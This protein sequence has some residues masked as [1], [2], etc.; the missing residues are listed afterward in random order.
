MEEPCQQMPSSTCTRHFLS[1]WNRKLVFIPFR[2]VH[3]GAYSKF[4]H[5]PERL[6]EIYYSTRWVSLALPC[7]PIWSGCLWSAS[8]CDSCSP[9]NLRTSFC[10]KWETF[11]YFSFLTYFFFL[12]TEVTFCFKRALAVCEDLPVF[13]KCT[14]GTAQKV[15]HLGTAW[16]VHSPWRDFLGVFVQEQGVYFV[17]VRLG[18]LGRVKV[19]G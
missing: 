17:A 7:K 3:S 16:G 5:Y 15:A 4:W 2:P 11:F 8:C 1:V 6:C 19:P 9:G 12:S 14:A 18:Q 13:S 10:W